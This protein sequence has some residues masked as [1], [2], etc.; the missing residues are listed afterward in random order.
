MYKKINKFAIMIIVGLLLMFTGEGVL[1][2]DLGPS[3]YISEYEKLITEDI[4]VI[5]S[6][7]DENI[8]YKEILGLKE[9]INKTIKDNTVSTKSGAK[10]INPLVS[11]DLSAMQNKIFNRWERIKE[12]R[13]NDKIKYS[14]NVYFMH[15][16][17][18]L[19]PI[20]RRYSEDEIVIM[21]NT[22]IRFFNEIEIDPRITT[23]LHVMI[24]GYELNGLLGA[25]IPKREGSTNEGIIISIMPRKKGES[26]VDFEKRVKDTLLHE[27]GHIFEGRLGAISSEKVNNSKMI[28]ILSKS[29]KDLDRSVVESEWSSSKTENLAEDFRL[30]FIDKLG[31][32][33]YVGRKK[34]TIYKYN[35]GLEPIFKLYH[36]EK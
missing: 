17:S 24:S 20:S 19:S 27:L 12:L 23:D 22:T 8:L 9:D 25:A 1:A 10:I 14:S 28:D 34:K 16:Y 6:I 32:E 35:K 13:G 33:S 21:N 30:Y 4:E 11:D 2:S 5:K 31:N 26:L 29:E 18:R 3:K 36:K 15:V 7:D